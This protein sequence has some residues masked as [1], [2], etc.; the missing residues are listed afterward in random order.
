MFY[1]FFSVSKILNFQFSPKV[2]KFESGLTHLELRWCFS[3]RKNLCTYQRYGQASSALFTQ[4]INVICSVNNASIESKKFDKSQSIHRSDSCFFRVSNFLIAREAYSLSFSPKWDSRVDVNRFVN[5]HSQF[6][7]DR[8]LT[9]AEIRT[10]LLAAGIESNPGPDQIDDTNALESFEIV[11]VNCNGLTCNLRLLQTISKLKKRF[12]NKE[13]IIFLQETHNANIILL[14]SI[15]EGSVNVSP[16]TGGSRG[17]ITLCT[18]K[19]NTIS[20]KTDEQGRFL[21]TTI[22]LPD[23]RLVNTVNLYSPNDHNQSFQFISEVFSEW[24]GFCIDSLAHTTDPASISSV[25]AGDFNCV[26]NPQDSQQRSWGSKEQRLADHILTNIEN[27]DLYDS[28][29][30]SQ[31]GNNFTWNRG[32]TFSKIDHVFVSRDL[33]ESTTKYATVWDLIKS[34]HAAIQLSINLN[35]TC[36]RGRS[37]PKLSIIDLKGEDTVRIIKDEITKAINEFPT[38]W[39]PHL[40][41]DYVK[42]VI[43]TKILEIRAANKRDRNSIQVLRDKVNYYCSLPFLDSQ[44]VSEFAKARTLLYREEELEAERLRLAAGIKWREQGER[45]NKFFLNAINANRASST[46]DY[47]NTTEGKVTSMNEI[48]NYAKDFYSNLYDKHPTNHIDNFYQHC[49]LLSRAAQQ[50]ISLPL[51]INDLKKALKSCKDSTPG[52][53]GIPY[54]YYKIFANELLPLVLDA[55]EYSNVTGSLPQSQSTSVIS[56][57][58]KAGK[59]KHEIKNW[60][61]I[62]ISPCDL[63]IITKAY[64]LKVGNYLKEIISDSQMGYVP[65]RDINFNNRIIRL[66]LDH[67]LSSNIDYSIMSLD[68][69]KAYDSV[70]HTYISNTLKA[71][72]FP[73][74]FVNVV[75]ILHNNLQA[76]VQINGFKSN[77]FPVCRGVKQGDALS[78]ALFIIAIDPLIR[79]IEMN[80]NIPPLSFSESCNI[81]SLAYADDIAIISENSNS[82]FNN[83][84]FEYGKLTEMSGLTLN[85]DK[86]EIMNLSQSD[87]QSTYASYLNNNLTINHKDQITI[88]GNCIS[89]DPSVCY[90]VNITDKIA[91]LCK[92]L[93]LWKGRHL[94]INGKMIILKTFAISQLIYSSQFQVISPKD[95]R[96]IEHI[97]YKFLWNGPDRVKRA[98]LKSGRDEGGINGIDIESFFYAIAVR[99][100]FKSYT[101]KILAFANNSSNIKEDIKTHARTI[102][103]KLLLHQIESLSSSDPL[104]TQWISQTRADYLVKPYSKTHQ[105]MERLKIN[106]VS[107]I[108]HIQLRKGELSQLRRALP[109]RILSVIDNASGNVGTSSI[110]QILIGNNLK[111]INKINSKEIN[112]S[113]KTVLRKKDSYHPSNKYP[114]DKNCFE[115]IRITWH[116]LWRIKNPTL[117]AIRLKVLYKD[118]W[119]QEKRHKLG[120]SA[121]NKCTICGNPENVIHQLFLCDNARRIWQIGDKVT[122]TSEFKIIDNDHLTLAKLIE[123]SS[124]I[125]NE[126]IKS[127]IFKLLIQIDRSCDIDETE[128]RRTIAHW[129]NIEYIS[130][131]RVLRN[132]NLL[133]SNLNRIIS[134]LK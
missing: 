41:L 68:A 4:F 61:P 71:Y 77:V 93:N 18:R 116:N 128:I 38:H 15:W 102:I 63:K 35:N 110:L 130:L 30:R 33:L 80:R 101:N 83:I 86:T 82:S 69:Q 115:D 66:A 9:I 133:L 91:K 73:D 21:F 111:N 54:S 13:C 70:D 23:N 55:W 129:L 89:L 123:V 47:L 121:D 49:P 36:N 19:F 105:L 42:L 106:T 50:D 104:D 64:S 92:Q 75:D 32:N 85:A 14:E 109:S 99:Q 53:D 43:R 52:L 2:D 131:S 127:V 11:T 58:P 125:T 95:V 87:K 79:N 26:L 132:N 119:C 78:C 40:K 44:Q 1:Q 134:N 25:I 67:C 12:K 29:L 17:V 51:T 39:T 114:I 3:Q 74:S 7:N 97:C 34:D 28:T 90:K 16:G 107:S 31:N 27:Q 10:A 46:L 24:N 88:C 126:I 5:S 22:K 59:D 56:L 20:F 120:I 65:G 6:L 45:S 62:S 96:K 117:R 100:F 57:I 122:G 84:F 103:R 72:G 118:I 8:T 48:L 76:Q 112:D 113:I 108:S 37:Y 60:R 124:N 94:T 81:K 98:F